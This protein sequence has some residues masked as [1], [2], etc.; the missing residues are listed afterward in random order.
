MCIRDRGTVLTV[1]RLAAQRALEAAGERNDADY[2][3][4]EAIKTGY[5][6]LAE[7][8]LLYTSITS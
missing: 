2:V 7:T 8:C 4:E 5:A 3:L 6:T 1:S